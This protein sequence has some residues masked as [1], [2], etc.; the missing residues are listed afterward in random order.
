MIKA[1]HREEILRYVVLAFASLVMAVDYRTF[2][3]WGGLYPGGA[4]GL[5]M[6]VQRVAQKFEPGE[7]FLFDHRDAAGFPVAV[8]QLFTVDQRDA[9][10]R[11]IDLPAQSAVEFA[12][13]R[14]ARGYIHVQLRQ[15]A[16]LDELRRDDPVA[17]Q[18]HRLLRRL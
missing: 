9:S 1:K 17:R 12:D 6:L 10:H 7:F 15:M 16:G 11:G 3:E 18:L 2:V 5:A 4:A 14:T 8:R 13:H